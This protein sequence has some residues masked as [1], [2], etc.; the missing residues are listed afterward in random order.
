[1]LFEYEAIDSAGNKKKGNIDALNESI[2]ITSLQRRGLIIVSILNTEKKRSLNMEI[3]FFQRVSTKEVVILSRQI[4]TLFEAQVSAL[5]IFRLLGTEAE[6]PAL[7]KVMASIAEDLQGGSSISDALAKHDKVFSPFYV[8]MVR[9]GEESGKLEFVFLSLADYLDRTYEVTSK[10]RGALIYPAFVIFTFISVMT[11]MLTLVIP[12]LAEIIIESGQEIPFYTKI[13]IGIS[14]LLVSYGFLVLAAIII[15]GFM[16]YRYGQTPEGEL[17]LGEIKLRIP[18][19]GTLYHRLYL[20]RI[21][22][23]LST[24]IE[25]GVPMVRATELTGTVVGNK[26]YSEILKQVATDIKTGSAIS[27]AFGKYEEIPG[28]IVQMIKV[29]EETGELGKILKTMAKFYRREFNN[30][31]DT[32]ISLIEPAMIVFLGV[33]V[34]SLLASVLMP[35]YSISSSF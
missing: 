25:S 15:F 29:G 8:N 28:I 26:V 4:A 10:A 31:V 22:D 11:L 30:A 5:R 24:M 27:A 33:G 18:Y 17:A 19:V 6:N 7:Q 32:L 13:V 23:N 9:S 35:I 14:D 2:A 1:M 21:S 20:S 12:K 3:T 34:G 16:T